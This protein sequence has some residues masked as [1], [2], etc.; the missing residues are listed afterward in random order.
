MSLNCSP[1]CKKPPEDDW[2]AQAFQEA[3]DIL[4]SDGAGDLPDQV[5]DDCAV[6]AEPQVQPADVALALAAASGDREDVPVS[7]KGWEFLEKHGWPK[8]WAAPMVRGS[9][10]TWRM[11]VRKHG[12][13]IATSPMIV[14]AG[15]ARSAYYRSMFQFMPPGEGSDRPLVIQI[16]GTNPQVML[17]AAR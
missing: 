7:K 14:A 13:Q 1:A 6:L 15:Y 3:D 9:E 17:E 8:F 4:L 11:Q 16:A 10:L 2:E 12:V 5:C